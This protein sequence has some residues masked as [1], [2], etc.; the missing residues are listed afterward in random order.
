MRVLFTMA[1]F[2]MKVH[3]L[4]AAYLAVFVGSMHESW[5]AYLERVDKKPNR[6]SICPDNRGVHLKKVGQRYGKNIL[7]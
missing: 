6:C 4:G 1:N 7:S 2:L 5:Q 3:A